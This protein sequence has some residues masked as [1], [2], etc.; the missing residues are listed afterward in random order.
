[1]HMLGFAETERTAEWLNSKGIAAFIFKYRVV[2]NTPPAEGVTRPSKALIR[3]VLA[4]GDS[5]Q[6]GAL[7]SAPP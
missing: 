6:E 2:P 5:Q 1:M 3:N 4:F 7:L